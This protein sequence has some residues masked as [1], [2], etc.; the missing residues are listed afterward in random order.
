MS[1]NNPYSALRYQFTIVNGEFEDSNH[2]DYPGSIAPSR[3]E[4][5]EAVARTYLEISATPTVEE[6]EELK[7]TLD[8]FVSDDVLDLPDGRAIYKLDETVREVI[9]RHLWVHPDVYSLFYQEVFERMERFGGSFASALAN[10]FY[11]ADIENRK[12]IIETWGELVENYRTLKAR[13]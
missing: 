10:C 7:I 8:S 2:I 3:A 11:R 1:K 9:Y 13:K 4:L 12:L 5:C 6:A